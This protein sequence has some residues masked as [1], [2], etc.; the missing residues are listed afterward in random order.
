MGSEVSQ[1][2]LAWALPSQAACLATV[3]AVGV[4]WCPE[5]EVTAKMSLEASSSPARP[6]KTVSRIFCMPLGRCSESLLILPPSRNETQGVQKSLACFLV[7]WQSGCSR[8]SPWRNVLDQTHALERN[9]MVFI[10]NFVYSSG[11]AGRWGDTCGLHSATEETLI[12]TVCL[13]VIV[14]IAVFAC[15]RVCVPHQCLGPTEVKRGHEIS[16]N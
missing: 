7:L 5:Q 13:F 4:G 2:S 15:M 12:S 6:T 9:S 10:G 16:Q 1:V 8:A 3:S 14:N 11:E